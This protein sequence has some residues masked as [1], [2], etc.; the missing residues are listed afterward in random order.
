[1]LECLAHQCRSP[2]RNATIRR[3]GCLGHAR[4]EGEEGDTGGEREA[5]WAPRREAESPLPT[6]STETTPFRHADEG[7]P[8]RVLPIHTE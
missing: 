7:A 4:D 1:M 8:W 6:T 3:S 5:Q 2:C